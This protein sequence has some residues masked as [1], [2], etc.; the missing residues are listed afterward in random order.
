M[1]EHMSH[2]AYVLSCRQRAV[3][4]ATGVLDGTI[5]VLEACHDLASLRWE[6]EVDPWDEDFTT[7]AGISS[8]TDHL[9]VGRVR[10]HWSTDALTR[11]EPQIQSAIA[12][13]MPQA[14]P[15]CRSVVSRFQHFIGNPS[16]E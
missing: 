2:E 5:N 16:E 7:F 14:V 13:A 6:V 8:E 15:A 9:P 11:L 12:W 3:D 1:I 4:L 10:D